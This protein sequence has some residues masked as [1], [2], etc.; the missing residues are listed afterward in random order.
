MDDE[1]KKV[2]TKTK[3]RLLFLADVVKRTA[4]RCG[5]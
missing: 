3:A 1:M 5:R 2:E 4:R